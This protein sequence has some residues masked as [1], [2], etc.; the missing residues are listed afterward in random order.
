MTREKCNSKS[1]SFVAAA[2]QVCLQ[3]VLEHRQRRGR[4]NIAWQ[5]IS[6]LCCSSRKGT[7]SDSWQ[8]TGRNGKLFSGSGP[9]PASVCQPLGRV[10]DLNVINL[11]VDND[12]VLHSL[13]IFLVDCQIMVSSDDALYKLT[14]TLHYHTHSTTWWPFVRDYPG[15]PIREETYPL[16]PILSS[17]IFYQL[18]PS[19]C[20]DP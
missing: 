18:R 4:G 13:V 12:N 9:E 6:H 17:D 3:P 7:T 1:N 16:T 10:Q 5:A 8:T 19:I 20:Y 15:R 2:E 11:L 14:F